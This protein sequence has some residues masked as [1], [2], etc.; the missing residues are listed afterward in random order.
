MVTETEGE[1][2]CADGANR[3]STGSSSIDLANNIFLVVD[4]CIRYRTMS[5]LN[6]KYKYSLYF[7]AMVNWMDTDLI[8]PP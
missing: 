1:H 5:C 2:Q 7:E 3:I 4:V 8:R 6:S